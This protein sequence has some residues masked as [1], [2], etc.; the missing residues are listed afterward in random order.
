MGVGVAAFE[1]LQAALRLPL[2]LGSGRG[3]G[4]L[5]GLSVT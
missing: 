2:W 1:A 4:L 5:Q 3:R